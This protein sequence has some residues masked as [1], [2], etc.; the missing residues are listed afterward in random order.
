MALGIEGVYYVMTGLSVTSVIVLFLLPS[1]AFKPA[2][3]HER[4]SMH[5][6]VG[7]GLHYIKDH[8][9]IVWLILAFMLSATV[10]MPHLH[11]MPVLAKEAWDVEAS[12]VGLLFSMA[13]MG[14]FIGSLGMA[15]LGDFRWKGLLLLAITAAFGA[16]VV[17]L[18]LSPVYLAA[19]FVL[20]PL[21][22]FQS[23]RISLNSALTQLQA[24]AEIRGRA[25]G[26]YHMETGVHPFGILGIS[27]LADVIGPEYALAISGR[28]VVLVCSYIYLASPE[29]RRLS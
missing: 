16:G 12:K 20:A 18:A 29:M 21:G 24:H 26:V 28:M 22:I 19:L 15:T 17:A 13:G 8:R 14:A 23:A 9:V 6:N 27:V 10:G 4:Q 3:R 25:M 2:V 5:R 11:L 1:A 7:E